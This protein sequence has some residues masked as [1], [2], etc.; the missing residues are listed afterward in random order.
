M[1]IRIPFCVLILLTVGSVASGQESAAR[2]QDIIIAN[3]ESDSY[4]DWKVDGDA[5]GTGPTLGYK[6]QVSGYRGRRLVNSFGSGDS[7]TGSLTSPAFEINRQFVAFL[8]GGGRHPGLTGIELLIDDKSVRS[9]TGADSG[10]LRWESWDVGDLRGKQAR[11]CIF[12]REQGGWGHINLDQILLT[13]QLRTGS[14]TWRLDEYRRSSEYYREPFRPAYHFTPEL[15][16]MNDPNGLVYFEGEYHLFYQHNPLGNEWGH[17]SWGHAVSQDLV[18]WRHLPIALRDEYG[19][20]IFSGSAVADTHNTSGFGNG[21]KP[22]LVAIYTG[23]SPDRQTQDIA[24]STDR[25]RTWTKYAGNPVLDVGEKDFR[26]PKVFWHEPTKRWIMVVSLAVQ[27]RLQFYGSSDLK[28]W[29]LLSEFGPAGAPN[30]LNWEC[31]DLFELPIDGEPGKTRWVLA[32]HMGNGA[33]AGGSGC[34][35]F[36][37]VFD[38]KQFLPDATTSQWVDYGRDFYAPVSWSGIPASD[39]RR[40]WIGWMNNWETCLNPT[41]PWRS[42]MSIPRELD[43]RRIDGKLRLCQKPVRELQQLRGRKLEMNNKSLT[44]ESL[45][46]DIQGQQLEILVDVDPMTASEFGVRVLK[47]KDEQ[48]AIGYNTKTRALFV[49]R[50]KSGNVAFHSAFSGRHSGP[51]EPNAQGQVRLHI[52]VDT[53]SVEVFGNEGETVVTDLVFPDPDSNRVELFASGG[54]CKLVFSQIHSLKSAWSSQA[55]PSP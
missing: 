43:L 14:G 38:G 11:I 29:K 53:C 13:D 40:I 2:S 21:G 37:G 1:I 48:T 27:K 9:A 24:F 46:V 28:A 26:D 12:D 23:H 30:K 44:N 33:I 10:Q 19:I 42:A 54:T 4:G 18:H 47:G 6:L 55:A 49:D 17:M 34:E 5:F 35:C 16:W 3:F 41:S 31:P 32:A 52:F 8:I 45:P 20:M 7:A 36:T 39:G 50:T 22:P 25:G 51:L 15:N